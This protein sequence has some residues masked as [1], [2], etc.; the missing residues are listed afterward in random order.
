MQS[1]SRIEND[2]SSSTEC[3]KSGTKSIGPDE[4]TELE[5]EIVEGQPE[6][7]HEWSDE[8]FIRV[9]NE[10]TNFDVYDFNELIA[11]NQKRMKIEEQASS[12][13]GDW[14]G[15]S[16]LEL[17]KETDIRLKL[18]YEIEYIAN[19]VSHIRLI[20]F[21]LCWNSIDYNPWLTVTCKPI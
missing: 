21:Y 14:E 7:K 5:D 19:P 16:A 11:I 6:V 20:R 12:N 1:G 9:P 4:E 2:E 17:K 10:P 8:S 18:V 15:K 3:D 13:T